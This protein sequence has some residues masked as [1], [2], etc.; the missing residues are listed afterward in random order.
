MRHLHLSRLLALSTLTAAN[1]VVHDAKQQVTYHGLHRNGIEVFLNIPYGQDTGGRNRFR[2]PRAHIPARGSS[3]NATAYGPACPQA[4]GL[5]APPIALDPITRISEDCLNL[6][7]ARPRRTREATARLLPVL[8]YIHGGSFWAGSNEESTIRP[9]GMI[10]ESVE[11]GLPVM[12]VAM[13]YRLGFFGF[14]QSDALQ[15]EGSENAGLRDQRLALEWVRDNIASFGGDPSRVTIFGQSSGGLSVGMHIMAYGGTK[16]AP[17]QQAIAESQSLEPG[18]TGSF[19]LNAMRRLVDHVGCGQATGLHSGETVQC[20]RGL[21][22]GT[23]LNAS[24]ATY[25]SDIAHNIGDIWL[26][27]VDGDFLPAAPSTLVREHRFADVTAMMG[28]CDDDVTFF[29]DQNI[30]TAGDTRGFISSY[31]PSLSGDTLDKLL[32]LYHPGSP[33]FSPNRAANLS[34]E[35]YRAAR[36]FRDILMV[37]LPAGYAEQMAAAGNTV[38]LYDW[39]QTVLDPYLTQV[40]KRPGM[41]V[42][43]TS[44]FAYIFGNLSHYDTGAYVFGPSPSDYALATRGSRSWSTFASTGQPGLAGHDTFQRFKPAFVADEAGMHVFVVG[45]PNEGPSP[46]EWPGAQVALRRQRLR[47]R[48]GLINSAEFIEQLRY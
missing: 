42:I 41:G 6:N 12:H 13:N 45:G 40:S 3:V 8:V 29:T 27:V 24:I 26:P 2:P 33:E 1:P 11:N 19:T 37:C 31:A 30:A 25:A 35:F 44:E 20:L 38:Y 34:A 22:A 16:P 21:D 7:V 43:H 46:V 47:E 39:N 14:A 10:L 9:D 4:L 18:I 32:A 23:L 28:W 36:I 17:F 15:K 48:C 5:W